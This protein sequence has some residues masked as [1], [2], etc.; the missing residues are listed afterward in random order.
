MRVRK[1]EKLKENMME[2]DTLKRITQN[3][4]SHFSKWCSHLKVAVTVAKIQSRYN[5]F[6]VKALEDI[7]FDVNPEQMRKIMDAVVTELTDGFDGGHI[8]PAEQW[9]LSRRGVWRTSEQMSRTTSET[10]G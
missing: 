6:I 4:E 3:K 8:P 2:S 1:E 5:R 7:I 9:V 10:R